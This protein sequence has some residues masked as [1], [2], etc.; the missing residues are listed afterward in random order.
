MLRIIGR[1]QGEQTGKRDGVVV[2]NM[3]KMPHLVGKGGMYHM[4]MVLLCTNHICIPL[5]RRKLP[6]V[7]TSLGNK[8]LTFSQSEDFRVCNPEISYLECS[9]QRLKALD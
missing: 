4:M 7:Q 6:V 1:T 8:W 5:I 2:P 9:F 3:M